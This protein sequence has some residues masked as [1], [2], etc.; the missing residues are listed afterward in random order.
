MVSHPSA[1]SLRELYKKIAGRINIKPIFIPV[2]WLI[3]YYIVRCMEIVGFK[4]S[5]TAENVL[6]LKDLTTFDTTLDL[7]IFGL[8]IKDYKTTL[9]RLEF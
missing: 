5:F 7:K 8:E 9:D 6:G 3:T 1:V 4:L 2:P